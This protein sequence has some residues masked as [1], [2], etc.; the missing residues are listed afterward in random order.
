MVYLTTMLVMY[1]LY[2][3]V[4]HKLLPTAYIKMID[5]WLIVCILVPFCEVLLHTWLESLRENAIQQESL[6]DNRRPGG[7]KEG[8]VQVQP[9]DENHMH[10]SQQDNLNKENQR[11]GTAVMTGIFVGRRLIPGIIALFATGY[12]IFGMS[13]YFG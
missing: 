10:Y 6:V 5:I 11:N 12:W 13:H 4:S 8:C 7:K 9:K 3:S 1:T 2:Q